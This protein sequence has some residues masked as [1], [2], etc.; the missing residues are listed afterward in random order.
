[1]EELM[2]LDL[3]ELLNISIDAQEKEVKKA[4]RKKALSCHPD[5]NPD[6]PKAAELF[7]QLSKA[8]EILSDKAARTA[9]DKVLNARKATQVRHRELDSKRKKLKEDL[10]AKE[11]A[12]EEERL[13][14]TNL[15]KEIERL[16][17]EGSKLLEEENER[18]R[19]QIEK[20]KKG[21]VNSTE[22]NILPRL[23][24]KW[25][26]HKTDETNGG[27]NQ[28]ILE[29]IFLKYGH[30]MCLVSSKKNGS[31]I[32]EF[33]TPESAQL[34]F[35][36]EKGNPENPLTLSWISGQPELPHNS[37]FSNNQPTFKGPAPEPAKDSALTSRDYESLVLMKMRQAEE[38]KRL[39]EQ[40]ME[41]ED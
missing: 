38:R 13:S 28:N 25:K 6:N 7:Q 34:A 29:S 39:I 16:R 15:E 20:E 22:A 10:E 5:K 33:T 2:K 4:Y 12:A 3:Y 30:V 41:N 26:S 8:L 31:A 27:Y 9:Y 40:M 11:K 24:V 17:R 32:L 21:G 36:S 23:K 1:M 18:I 14:T 35:E 37:R 19:Q